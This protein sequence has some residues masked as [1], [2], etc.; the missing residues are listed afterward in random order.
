MATASTLQVVFVSISRK[1][2]VASRL[3]WIEFKIVLSTANIPVSGSDIPYDTGLR[4]VL[5][6][7]EKILLCSGSPCGFMSDRVRTPA[8]SE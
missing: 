3:R 5:M 7:S 6:V 4:A 1:A 2:F 8:T